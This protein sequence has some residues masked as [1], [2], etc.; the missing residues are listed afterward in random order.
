MNSIVESDETYFPESFKGPRHLPISPRRRNGKTAKSDTSKEQQLPVLMVRNRH[1]ETA[2]YILHGT[3]AKQ[4]G[5]AL[6][7]QLNKDVI[8]CT[9]GMP[10]YKQIAR[11][12]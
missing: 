10:A 6:M 7:L 2:D 5:T 3:S 8:L 1:G 9:D 12:V 11:P 4:I